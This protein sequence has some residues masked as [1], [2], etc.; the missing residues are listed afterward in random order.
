MVH[1]H[2]LIVKILINAVYVHTTQYIGFI[3]DLFIFRLASCCDR[4]MSAFLVKAES[5][6]FDFRFNCM[7]EEELCKLFKSLDYYRR[8]GKSS[9]LP[10]YITQFLKTMSLIKGDCCKWRTIVRQ[11]LNGD[12]DCFV[13][14]FWTVLHLVATRQVVLEHGLARVPVC[15]LRETV[16]SLFEG[17]T[18]K[19]IQ[20]AAKVFKT[21]D[22]RIK[23]LLKTIKVC[24]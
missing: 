12:M 10:G 14:P 18:L 7:T 17:L 9:D 20:H 6:L 1:V 23:I 2:S 11:Y 15:K 3:T 4:E 19:G 8:A 16:T 5:L 21:D 24:I 13:V 22:Q